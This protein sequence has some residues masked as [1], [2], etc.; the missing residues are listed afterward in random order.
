MIFNLP[1]TTPY[2]GLII[3][4][5]AWPAQKRISYRSLMPYHNIK[6]SRKDRLDKQIIQEQRAKNHQNAYYQKVRI[7]A[8]ELN[9]K[10]E[11]P[12]TIKKSQWK[13]RKK[14]KIQD[15]IQKRV[16]KEMKNKAELRAVREDKLERKEYIATCNSDLVQ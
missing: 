7:M 12:A 16:E 1:I 4:T 14:D 11:A 8:E 13:T 5:G 15:Q 2:I 9:I 3:Q 10:L 6:N